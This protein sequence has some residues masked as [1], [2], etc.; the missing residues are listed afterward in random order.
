MVSYTLLILLF[1][2]EPVSIDVIPL[3]CG[4]LSGQARHKPL[5][6]LRFIDFSMG[7]VLF[8]EP[9]RKTALVLFLHPCLRAL[10]IMSD[11]D[12]VQVLLNVG[13]HGH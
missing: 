9:H 3:P 4:D 8:L 1:H 10:P 11:M 13:F 6:G 12:L 7:Y 5:N 2:V